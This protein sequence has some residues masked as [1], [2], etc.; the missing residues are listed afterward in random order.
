MLGSGKPQLDSREVSAERSRYC[1]L[2]EMALVQPTFQIKA[3][4]VSEIFLGIFFNVSC[5]RT[6]A[7]TISDSSTSFCLADRMR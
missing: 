1:K 7:P 4:L 6:Q 2:K 3:K 5:L